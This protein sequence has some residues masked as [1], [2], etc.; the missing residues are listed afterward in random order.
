M[1]K[2]TRQEF[3][4]VRGALLA[5]TSF[6]SSRVKNGW[7]VEPEELARYLLAASEA[8]TLMFEWAGRELGY[9]E[10]A[11]PAGEKNIPAAPET[12]TK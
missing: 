5:Q 9:I 2:I 3:D 1:T 10:K 8:T 7:G 12:E 4:R 6:L 11:A